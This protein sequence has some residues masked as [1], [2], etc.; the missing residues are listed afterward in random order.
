MLNKWMCV[1][2]KQLFWKVTHF[3]GQDWVGGMFWYALNFLIA[4]F[5]FLDDS[6]PLDLMF[7]FYHLPNFFIMSVEAG[8]LINV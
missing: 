4:S 1:S 7:K 8:S 6:S 5:K 2:F 3:L